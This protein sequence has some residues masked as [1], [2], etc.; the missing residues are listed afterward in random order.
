MLLGFSGMTAAREPDDPYDLDRFVR[1]QAGDYERA[2]AEIRQ[3]RKRSHWMWFIFPQIDGLG[4]SAI[5]RR[6]SIKSLDEARAYLD[7]PVLGARLNQAVE[8][9]L[10]LSGPS[11]N[12]IFG[13]PDEMKLQSCATLFALVSEAGSVFHRLLDKYFHGERDL[14]TLRLLSA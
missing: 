6:Y 8:T 4:S 12:E 14:M 2:L 5:S 1:A 13:F 9:L 7:H 11:A 10:K 3:G